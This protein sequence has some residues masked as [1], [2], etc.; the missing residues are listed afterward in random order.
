VDFQVKYLKSEM[1]KNRL[2]I[3]GSAGIP[4]KYGGFETLSQYLVTYLDKSVKITVYCSSV[5]LT[6]RPK[7]YLNARLRYI[8]LK[9][10]GIQS[11][12]YDI[13]SF[14]HAAIKNDIILVLGVSGCLILPFFRLF[15]RKKRIIINID[16]LEHKRTKWNSYIQK[17]LKLS[18]YIAIHNSDYIIA[19]N[20]AIQQYITNSYKKKSIF[21]PYGGDH[22]RFSAISQSTRNEYFIP[23]NYAL[24][25]CRI[26]PENNLKLILEAFRRTSYY[27]IIIGNWNYS[28][29][30]LVLKKEYSNIK[31][32]I[33]LEA[34]YNQDILDQFRSN[35]TIYL[36]GHSAGGTNPSLVEAMSL[37][38]P[39]FAFDVIYNRE[40]TFNC[41]NY[42]KDEEELIELI[43]TATEKDLKLLGGEMGKIAR[44]NYTWEKV[45]QQYQ[46]VF[47]MLPG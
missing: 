47:E 36:H 3:V 8:P 2:A 32:I 7:Y 37:S 22:V 35:C 25:I 6:I 46:E 5:E 33:L 43:K 9:A 1:T 17:F 18:E 20:L 44:E 40:T 28:K 39:I 23:K 15:V 10:N 34:I 41:A 38:L 11:I 42:F 27:L 29:F 19:D 24:K 45:S 16:G 4:A 26:E 31:N 21:I 13:I 12:F 30:G 14:F